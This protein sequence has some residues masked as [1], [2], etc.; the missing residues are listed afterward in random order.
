MTR[1]IITSLA[2]LAISW[3][4]VAVTVDVLAWSFIIGAA[5]VCVLIPVANFLIFRGWVF[6]THMTEDVLPS[7]Q[8]P[9]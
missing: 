1:F 4:A 6:A 8:E 7:A 2:G 5:V 3:C 9:R